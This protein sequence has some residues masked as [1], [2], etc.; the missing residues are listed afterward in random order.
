M[1]DA[2]Y[3][4]AHPLF[5]IRDSGLAAGFGMRHGLTAPFSLPAASPES[6][7]PRS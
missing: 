7:V 4:Q 3:T 6:R 5:G 1:D 2:F